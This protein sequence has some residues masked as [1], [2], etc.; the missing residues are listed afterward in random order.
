MILEIS[1]VVVSV[2]SSSLIDH[3]NSS[4][5]CCKNI[6]RISLILGIS[7]ESSSMEKSLYDC[8]EQ[9]VGLCKK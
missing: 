6:R 3:L 7:V 2:L 8:L 1:T 4:I 5:A 9:S